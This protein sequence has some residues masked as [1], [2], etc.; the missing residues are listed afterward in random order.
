M[1]VCFASSIYFIKFIWLA[2]EIDHK[3]SQQIKTK[4]YEYLC[5]W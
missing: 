3:T 4:P 1:G 2:E 5:E